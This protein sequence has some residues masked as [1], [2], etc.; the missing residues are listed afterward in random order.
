ME[1][2]WW[3]ILLWHISELIK[4]LLFATNPKVKFNK[5]FYAFKYIVILIKNTLEYYLA[6]SLNQIKYSLF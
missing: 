6:V 4:S 5:I 2:E 3:K 1:L